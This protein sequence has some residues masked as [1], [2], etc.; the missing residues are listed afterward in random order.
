MAFADPSGDQLCVL[1]AEIHDENGVE[2]AIGSTGKGHVTAFPQ[3][4]M[5]YVQSKAPRG[6]GGES[7][8]GV[9]VTADP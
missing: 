5:D 7:A 6:P 3:V 1:R 8:G 2:R 4:D 9:C